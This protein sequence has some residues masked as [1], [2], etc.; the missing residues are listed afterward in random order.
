[1]EHW[2]EDVLD[3]LEN[4]DLVV[5]EASDGVELRGKQ[6]MLTE[7]TSQLFEKLTVQLDIQWDYLNHMLE[8]RDHA[9]IATKQELADFLKKCEET[10]SS[11]KQNLVFYALDDKGYYYTHEGQQGRWSSATELLDGS[12]QKNVFWLLIGLL[13]RIRW[14]LPINWKINYK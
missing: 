13:M 1:M 6:S 10:L 5:S 4:Q 7:I 3:T 2:A 9:S 14:C 8:L 11:T 12:E